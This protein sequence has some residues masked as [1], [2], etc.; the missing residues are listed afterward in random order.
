M[1]KRVYIETDQ[2]TVNLVELLIEEVR[3]L[4]DKIDRLEERLCTPA[5][6]T[7][8]LLQLYSLEQTTQ[9]LN[10]SHKTLYNIRREGKISSKKIKGRVMFSKSDVERYL[11][12]E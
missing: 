12:D 4:N 1:A 7:D 6:Q 3:R 9:L 5:A 2:H 10:I 8:A 11:N